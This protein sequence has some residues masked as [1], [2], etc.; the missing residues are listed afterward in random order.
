MGAGAS[1]LPP[2]IDKATAEAFAG[3]KFDAD[4]WLPAEDG[5]MSRDDFLKA[6][7]I[8]VVEPAPAS[9]SGGKKAPT[10]SS[11]AKASG[12]KGF[13]KA[14]SV[15]SAKS[16]SSAAAGG[17]KKAATVAAKKSPAASGTAKKKTVASGFAGKVTSASSSSSSGAAEATAVVAPPSDPAAAAEAA[18]AEKAAAE[19]ERAT[20]NGKVMVRYNHYDKTYEVVDGRLNWEHVD[21]EYAISFVFKGNWTCNL[22]CK[23]SGERV[24]PDGGA[25]HTEMR[26]DP[27]GFD[28]DEE[29]EKWCGFFSG[30]TVVDAD[31]K[32]REYVL[33]VQEDAVWDEAAR[34]AGTYKT[35]KAP[36]AEENGIT[37]QKQE[38]CSCIE[39]NPCADAY[40]CKDW[41]N[42]FEVAKKH[43][44]KGFS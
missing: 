22:L 13:Q 4:K 34:A 15:P 43:G 30:L 2:A 39:G 6:A 41:K 25:L 28:P 8:A 24:T 9:S 23:A 29:E 21:D 33:E 27:D 1:A 20:R 31:G 7:G 38:S 42:R 18:A 12:A 11:G 16:K 35:Y 3:A 37:K 19:A 32:P 40:C 17:A 26:K 14:A 10:S 44:W 36:T 5:T